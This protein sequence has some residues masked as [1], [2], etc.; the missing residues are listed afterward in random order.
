MKRSFINKSVYLA[1]ALAFLPAIARAA[2]WRIDPSF[3][4]R[5]GYNDNIRLSVQNEVSSAEAGF[6][7]RASFSRNTEISGLAGIVDLD[8]R[9]YEESSDL[10]E[11]NA[12][13]EL[14]G[15]RNLERGRLS[16]NLAYINDTTLNTQLEAT[17]I[18]LGRVDR[19]RYTA[20]PGWSYFFSPR[21][22]LDLRYTFNDVSYSNVGL[23]P[24]IDYRVNAGQASLVSVLNEQITASATLS[25]SA[26]TNDNDVDSSNTGLNVGV[27]YRFSKTLTA[28]L[29]AGARYTKTD[30]TRNTS[31]PILDGN[32]FVG[33]IPLS[34]DISNSD[35]GYTYNVSFKRKGLRGDIELSASQ[36]ISN[37]I[38]GQPIEVLQ[39]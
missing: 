27:E 12:R 13:F 10:D 14:D 4:F 15:Y 23:V 36:N 5:A 25:H 18:T 6:S 19:Q 17:G 16:L 22:R 35:W 1:M 37:D 32:V 3:D 2:E 31:I 24:Y 7:P 29:S 11:N 30:F 28:S 34:Q 21:N 33:A 38:N 39:L 9:R 20:A 8:F 26:S